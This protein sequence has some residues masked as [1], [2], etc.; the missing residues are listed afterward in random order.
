MVIHVCFFIED[1]IV[2]SPLTDTPAARNDVSYQILATRCRKI[3]KVYYKGATGG[4]RFVE[5]WIGSAKQFSV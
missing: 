1:K 5:L 4:S 3:R 2:H